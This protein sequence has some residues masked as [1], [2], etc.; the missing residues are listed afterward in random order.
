M[1]GLSGMRLPITMSVMQNPWPRPADLR[2]RAQMAE[3]C[4]GL[5]VR[6]LDGNVAVNL[7]TSVDVSLTEASD[8]DA[9]LP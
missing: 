4:I 7:D 9:E 2:R 1:D 5:R 3:F 8:Q 6:Y